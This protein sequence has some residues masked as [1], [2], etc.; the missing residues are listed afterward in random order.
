LRRIVR[1]SSALADSA[2]E[3]ALQTTAERLID[4]LDPEA[5]RR[6]GLALHALLQ[7][8]G[9]L[10]PESWPAVI[11]KAMPVLLPEAPDAHAALGQK[12]RSILTRPDLAHL[13][14]PNSRAEVPIL[15]QGTRN[16]QKVTIAGRIDRLVVEP[17]RVRVVD[18]KSDA[19]AP[20]AL[21]GVPAAYL[22]QLG[23]YAQIAGLLFPGHEVAAAILW[24]DPESLMNLPQQLLREAV[25][26]FTVG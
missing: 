26:G 9:R 3:A 8:L 4:P 12:A 25:S 10:D 21:E 13:F 24:T 19:A 14:G 23:L 22:A 20:E 1:P 5:A 11:G 6:K 2:P 7:H 17:G 18:Y 15:A 16:G